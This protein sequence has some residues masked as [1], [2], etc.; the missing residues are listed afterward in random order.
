MDGKGCSRRIPY[1]KKKG[2]KRKSR[3]PHTT[4]HNTIREL[5]F[6]WMLPLP[7]KCDRIKGSEQKKSS[8][9][10]RSDVLGAMI[11]PFSLFLAFTPRFLPLDLS[12]RTTTSIMLLTSIHVTSPFWVHDVFH[13]A[14]YSDFMRLATTGQVCPGFM[15][16]HINAVMCGFPV[17]GGDRGWQGSFISFLVV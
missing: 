12:S 7:L 10:L 5:D 8:R 2:R 17:S 9:D 6:S 4:Q 13:F 14:L 16:R 1:S 11:T 15:L 3:T